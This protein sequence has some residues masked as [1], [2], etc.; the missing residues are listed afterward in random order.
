MNENKGRLSGKE[1]PP[2]LLWNVCSDEEFLCDSMSP[3]VLGRDFQA[4]HPLNLNAQ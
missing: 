1:K 3:I 4:K 2:N